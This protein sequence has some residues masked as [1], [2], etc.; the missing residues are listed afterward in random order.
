MMNPFFQ[1]QKNG[2]FASEA[3]GIEPEFE[4]LME[5]QNMTQ[6]K[7]LNLKKITKILKEYKEELKEK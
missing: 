3:P 2:F 5:A 4:K 7:V 6:T 1:D